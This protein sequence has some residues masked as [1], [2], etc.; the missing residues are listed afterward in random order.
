MA[1]ASMATPHKVYLSGKMGGLTSGEVQEMRAQAKFHCNRLGLGYYDPAEHEALPKDLTRTIDMGVTEGQ[2]RTYVE[3]DEGALD[4][5]TSI[6]VMTGDA[7]SDGT[8]WEMARAYYRLHIPIVMVAP[9]RLRGS[10]MG[11]SNIKLSPRIF[12]TIEG[13]LVYLK[14]APQIREDYE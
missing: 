9:R 1:K 6:L 2:M 12:E 3:S 8:W 10:L 14:H 4:H 5:C 7:P 11:F 13:A